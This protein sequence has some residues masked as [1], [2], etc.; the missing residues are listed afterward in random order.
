MRRSLLAILVVGLA[1]AAS[2]GASMQTHY[3][4]SGRVL[5]EAGTPI[6]GATVE[7]R[8]GGV[9]N[10]A[11]R[12][13]C[14]PIMRGACWQAKRSGP[15]GEYLLDFD[16]GPLFSN[17]RYAGHVSAWANDYESDVQWVPETPGQ[18]TRD[19]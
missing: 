2:L 13:F 16:A 7:V 4:I 18:T 12:S 3:K 1:V 8:H 15:A 6:I 5:N 11:P 19:I 9:G 17:Y 14:P 10:S